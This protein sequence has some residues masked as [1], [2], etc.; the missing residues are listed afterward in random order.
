MKWPPHYLQPLVKRL[1][2]V[3]GERR[4]RLCLHERAFRAH[5]C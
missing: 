1:D 4:V 2:S 3:R 5:V